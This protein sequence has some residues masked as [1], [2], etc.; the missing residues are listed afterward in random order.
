MSNKI[1]FADPPSSILFADAAGACVVSS[2]ERI[3]NGEASQINYSPQINM[4]KEGYICLSG[5]PLVERHAVNSM[6]EILNQAIEK[7]NIEFEDISIVIPHQAN[8]RIIESLKE[9]ILKEHPSTKVINVIEKLGNLSSASIVVALD[10]LRHNDIPDF[11]YQ[12]GQIISLTGVGGG[13]NYGSI[14]IEA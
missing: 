6:F 10:K 7:S 2:T 11:Q 14:V 4:K 5:G 1:D 13:Y 8:G 9:K 12:S 3:T